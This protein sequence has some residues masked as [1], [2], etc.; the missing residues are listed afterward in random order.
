M[1]EIEVKV[2][3]RDA[4]AARARLGAAGAVAR[5][6]RYFEDNRVYDDE[7]RSLERSGRLLRLRSIGNRHILT[8]KETPDPEEGA[9]RYK[10]RLEHET[11]VGD[12][13][14][15]D[16]I[17]R[18][19]GFL[20]AYRYQKYRQSY[21]LGEVTVE[22]DETPLGVFLELEGQPVDIDAAAERLGFG[23]SDYITK[24]YRMLHRER[25]RSETPGDLVFEDR[26]P[27]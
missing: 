22:L 20:V 1:R 12:P 24:T 17:L 10:V 23:P 15:A 6:P 14:E 9:E 26:P 16:R 8:L 11:T 5:T 3:V 13:H 18:S 25:S 4:D 2:E 21:R 27:A 19:L 7:S